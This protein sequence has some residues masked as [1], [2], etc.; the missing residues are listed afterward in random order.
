MFLCF[1]WVLC[2]IYYMRFLPLS[3]SYFARKVYSHIPP[4]VFAFFSLTL[5]TLCSGSFC[6]PAALGGKNVKR[7]FRPN[8]NTWPHLCHKPLQPTP[9]PRPALHFRTPLKCCSCCCVE[10][11]CVAAILCA[12]PV[13]PDGRVRVYFFFIFY[14]FFM[15]NLQL[16]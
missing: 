1:L 3:R 9:T 10:C 13:S 7:D 15:Q 6:F 16:C 5:P 2:S 11:R 12:V 8:A 4:F 14:Y